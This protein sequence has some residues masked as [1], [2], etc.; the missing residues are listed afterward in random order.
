MSLRVIVTRPASQA[1]DWAGRLGLHGLDAVALPLIRIVAAART[2]ELQAAW[3]ALDNLQLIVFV[4]PNAV[5]QF[6]SHRGG[7]GWPT[8][9]RAGSTGP[10]TTRELIGHGVP[11]AQIVAP[12]ADAAQLDSEA[13]WAQLQELPWSGARV[14][15]VRGQAGRDWLADTLRARGAQ[16]TQ[17]AA[18]GREAPAFTPA[19]LALLDQALQQPQRHLWLF[20][21]SQAVDNLRDLGGPQGERAWPRSRALATHPRIAQRAHEVG[22]AHVLQ[23]LPQFDAVV[24]CIQ[25]IEL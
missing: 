9:L 13:L 15:F 14:L 6:F 20:S 17:V 3:A 2:D 1:D 16:V 19:Q 18:Y 5:E 7:F 23:A 11:A 25:S 10:G 21:S 12:A 22:F 24:S 4:S 8:T